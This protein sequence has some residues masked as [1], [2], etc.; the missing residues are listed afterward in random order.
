[1]SPGKPLD[2]NDLRTI[3]CK[4]TQIKAG[5]RPIPIHDE[6]VGGWIRCD[7]GKIADR[8]VSAQ[9]ISGRA[10]ARGVHMHAITLSQAGVCVNDHLSGCSDGADRIINI[11]TEAIGSTGHKGI[12]TMAFSETD[13]IKLQQR[14]IGS[15]HANRII[16][17]R[18]HAAIAREIV[19]DTMALGFT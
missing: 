6:T 4:N 13:I 3:E 19:E 15:E 8:W 18:A 1:M 14:P 11:R 5:H 2:R 9:D 17:F 12:E 10:V 7:P 16:N